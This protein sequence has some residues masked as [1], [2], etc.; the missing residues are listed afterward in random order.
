VINPTDT[1]FMSGQ[2][3]GVYDY[4]LV[5]GLEGSGTVIASGGGF[6]AWTLVGKRVAFT[7]V[8]ERPGQFTKGGSYAEYCVTNATCC[9]TLDDG[10]SFEQGANGVINPL[11]ALGLLERCQ[12]RG[13]RG[14]IQTGAASQMGRMMIRLFQE[15]NIPVINIVR[16]DDQAQM[17]REKYGTPEQGIY[18]LNS[19]HSTFEPELKELA[20]KINANVVLEC[21]AGPIVGQIANCLPSNS[22]I[23]AYGQLSEQKIEGINPLLVLGRNL[24]LEGFL[25]S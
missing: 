2:Y 20:N 22:T 11:T 12:A 3:N 19:E 14:V 5:P 9:I 13:V 24:K 6:F 1:Y 17:L 21:V 8:L 23:V 16:K 10:V 7:R 25:L 15:N 4:P 18:V